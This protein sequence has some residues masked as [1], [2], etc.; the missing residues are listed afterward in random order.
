MDE[1]LSSWHQSWMNIILSHIWVVVI[2]VESV[3]TRSIIWI[4][5]R[6]DDTY[7]WCRHRHQF[8]SSADTYTKFSSAEPTPTPTLA[9]SWVPT[10]TPEHFFH[11]FHNI[12]LRLAQKILLCIYWTVFKSKLAAIVF[13]NALQFFKLSPNHR[14]QIFFEH[15]HQLWVPTQ[16]RH[17]PQVPIPTLV[18]VSV[19]PWI[20]GQIVSPGMSG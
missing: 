18:S 11:Y 4:T 9:M 20:T 13:L 2:S 5:A 1:V 17:Q 15:R 14:H 8:F 16:H 10:P 6:N 3:L 7:R 19:V 12:C